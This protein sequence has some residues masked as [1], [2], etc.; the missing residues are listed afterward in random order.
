MSIKSFTHISDTHGLH[1]Q[2]ANLPAA[3]VIIHSGDFTMAGT[4]EE[5]FDFVNWFCDLP[6]RYKIFI[7]GNHDMCL[8]G[9]ELSGLDNNCYYLCN[10]GIC[11]EGIN[12]YGVPMFMEDIM[13]DTYQE[14]INSIPQ[15]THILITHQPPYGILDYDDN[16]YYG[17]KALL[18]RVKEVKPKYHLFGH[19]HNA[20]GI[21]RREETTFSNGALV[22]AGYELTS[23]PVKFEIEGRR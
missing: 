15:D 17:D 18:Q 22:N 9:N 3:D 7:A 1:R 8:F 5:V 21:E 6:Y 16:R 10:S 14:S 20:N 12:I 11:I 19:I 13:S 23:V 2:L 4:K